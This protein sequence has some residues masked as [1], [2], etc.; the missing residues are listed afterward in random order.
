MSQPSSPY[1]PQRIVIHHLSGFKINQVE[2]FP[3]DQFGTLTFG[4]SR[5]VDVRYDSERHEFVSRRHAAIARNAD[6]SG[7]ILTDL[8]SRNGTF[9]NE[10]PV[11]DPTPIR[12]GD[13]VRLSSVGPAF[14]FTLDPTPDAPRGPTADTFPLPSL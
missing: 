12:P 9:L 14:V 3:A 13:T 4:R 2:A 11:T 8:G 7:Y 1:R 10:Q 6:N 5:S